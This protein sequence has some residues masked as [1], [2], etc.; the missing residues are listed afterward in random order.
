MLPIEKELPTVDGIEYV[1]GP[2]DI[3][4]LSL[5]TSSNMMKDSVFESDNWQKVQ[6]FNLAS[7]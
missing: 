2:T 5:P 3:G 6:V 4:A 7:I 1:N